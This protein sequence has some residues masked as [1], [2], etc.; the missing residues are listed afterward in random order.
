MFHFGMGSSP[1]LGSGVS[2]TTTVIPSTGTS[3]PR[4]FSLW[5]TPN[6]HNVPSNSQSGA[7]LSSMGQASGIVPKS[8]FFPPTGNP[9]F[10]HNPNVGF[11]YEWNWTSSAPV[12]SQVASSS[13]SDFG[14]N[15]E[16]FN[17]FG[18]P[19]IRGISG[20]FQPTHMVAGS[21][22][23]VQGGRNVPFQ[24][25][26]FGPGQMPNLS[27]QNVPMVPMGNLYPTGGYQSMP[28]PYPGSSP[29]PPNQYVGGP[30]GPFGL[31]TMS[32]LNQNS[33][34]KTQLPFLATLEFPNLSKLT[35]DPIMHH[36]AW[37]LVPVKIPTDIQNSK[38]R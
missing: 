32:P 3:I 37:P 31:N 9:S 26:P 24:L 20:P 23:H 5:S 35:N 10:S 4:T 6:V 27:N 21:N 34:V 17:P 13:Y 29:Y 7:G 16:G 15:L 8:V 25:P 14:Q 33:F 36:P 19:H 2:S 28:Q 1:L 38:E 22:T 11:P 12:G 30:Y 18:S